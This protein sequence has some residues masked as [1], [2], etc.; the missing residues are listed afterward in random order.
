MQQFVDHLRHALHTNKASASLTA[1]QSAWLITVLVGIV[2]TDVLNWAADER[3]GL[4][5]FRQ[6]RLRRMFNH[7][8]NKT[9]GIKLHVSSPG[10]KIRIV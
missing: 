3:R 6:S 1:C 5:V 2:V 7:A 4:K 9:C 8:K 10:G